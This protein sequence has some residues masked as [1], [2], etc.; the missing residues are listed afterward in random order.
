MNRRIKIII[1]ILFTLF[2]LGI[3]GYSVLKHLVTKSFPQYNGELT[4]DGLHYPVKIAR[5][6]FAVAHITAE[7]EHDLFFA[8][9]Y[10]HA[11][12]RLWQ[13]DIARRAG[14]GRLSEVL[15][16]SGLKFDRMLRTVGFKKIAEQ[17]EQTISPQSKAVLE[18][19]A[20]GVNAFIRTHQGKFPIEFDMLNYTPEE[21]RP[22]HSLMISRLMA[23][24]LN[25]SWHTDI[26]L[27]ELAAKLGEEKAS[28]VF[29]AYPENAPVI[30]DKKYSLNNLEP[31][32]YFLTTDRE[33]R[34]LFGTSGM[35]IGS[36]AW[37][38]SPKKTE[39]GYAML[40]NDPHLSLG[41]PAKWIEN[42]LSGGTLDVAG[43][44]L[45]G[46]PLVILGHNTTIAWGVTNVM[47]DDADFYFEKTDSLHPEQY[48]YKGEWRNF[49]TAYDTISVKDSASVPIKIQR[50]IHGPIVNS[51]YPI[52]SSSSPVI[53]M[54]WTGYEMSDELLGIYKINS[55]HNWKS[56]LE[57]VKEFTVPG[58]NFVYADREGNI[59]YKSGVRLPIRAAQNP[60]LPQDGS[61]G[62]FD[63]KGFVPFSELPELFNP[64][65]GFIATAN[66]KT[67]SSFPYHI[68]NLWEPPSRIERI[69]EVLSKTEKLTVEDF[70]RLQMDYYSHFAN[71][72]V[73]FLLAAYDTVS[74]SDARIRTVLNY[75]RN[76]NFQEKSSDVPTTIF[77]VYFQRLIRNIFL[78][79]MGEELFQQYI[80][81]A[82]MPYRVTLALMA[83]PQSS[84][85]DDIKT[86]P[87]ESRND[88][89][90]KSLSEAIDTLQ[91]HFGGEMKEWQWGKLHTITFKHLFGDIKVL[92]SIFNIGPFK[93][94][95][96]GTT[97]NNGE[98]HF[99][100]PYA[101]A[102]GPSVRCIVDFSK[103]DEAL[104]V[105][106]TGQ[107]GQ[108][109][110][111]HYS[112]Q[113]QMWLN[114]E[115]HQFP[116]SQEAVEKTKK[117]ELIL[118]PAEK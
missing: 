57:G 43:M 44:S 62:N 76:W 13:M 60:T 90:R 34:E 82:N 55:A 38:V 53:S 77:E 18:A 64:P 65:E 35:H 51:V 25:I 112:D 9:G 71:K 118:M 85:F 45:P 17:L 94:G 36:N 95:G 93:V 49:E 83:N 110:S 48:F 37:A 104:T 63:W 96:S 108:P 113:T 46:A 41:S 40:A 72:M 27:G 86:P 6:E 101:M 88:I 31:L 74:V 98:F 105:L 22:V 24:E 2:A 68:S 39:S 15:G 32:Q 54:A 109:L 23:W 91:Q 10:V 111:E 69:R 7:D 99:T 29:P 20:E 21:W 115:F 92:Q 50:T 11:Q 61:S 70:K 100:H 106:P 103:I 79:E 84:W 81:L 1:G 3:I 4:I 30:V 89:I 87:I 33:R 67:S 16:S 28:E 59:G 42:H 107:S 116:M 56:F 52:S 75:F 73:P 47:A 78:D 80:V 14:E 66:N 97:V 58:Q 5:D 102:L 114:G 8:Q 117:Y 12:E 26:V 19:Y